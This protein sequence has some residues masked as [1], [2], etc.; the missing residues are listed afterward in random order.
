MCVT[1]Y[2]SY[3]SHCSGQVYLLINTN[4]CFPYKWWIKMMM[5]NIFLMQK[6]LPVR[7]YP[8]KYILWI[9]VERCLQYCFI[10]CS[11]FNIINL[12]HLN[13]LQQKYQTQTSVDCI[14]RTPSGESTFFVTSLFLTNVVLFLTITN[15]RYSLNGAK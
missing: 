3:C 12:T 7:D 9:C 4:A 5:K 8:F 6:L 14:E 15:F 2:H 1:V 13:F 10:I 11:F